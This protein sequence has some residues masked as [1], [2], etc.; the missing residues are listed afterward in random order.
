[1]FVI[2]GVSGNVGSVAA[3]T[4]L[5]QGNKVRVLVRDA[6][7]GAA[8]SA[9]GA[10]VAVAD[11][12][13]RAA[14]TRAFQGAEGA[15]ILLPPVLKTNSALED[16]RT[17]AEAIAQAITDSK[18]PHVVLLSSVGAQHE[19]GTGPIRALHHAEK[20]FAATGV[21]LTAVRP[22]SFL[23]NW[24]GA[25]ATVPQGFVASFLPKD[26]VYSQVATADIGK[27]VA[28]ALVE[29]SPGA[30]RKRVI[31]LAGPRDWT[32]AEI[33]AAVATL[34]NKPISIMEAP[35]DAV[36]PTYAKFGITENVAGLYREMYEGVIT[37]QVVF[38]HP[39]RVVRGTVDVSD[40]LRP[41]VA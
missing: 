20:L 21:G 38:E 33:V 28:G 27:V 15:F 4:L 18:L 19:A 30:N 40:V 11:I 23:E 25:L 17:R 3:T 13:D 9:R 1:M 12:G 39:E 16:N 5:A 8:W 6:A 24:L 7:K 29:G 41:H 10:E 26:L 31:E 35:L 32:S 22:A 14:L 37:K 36:V 2:A 34:A